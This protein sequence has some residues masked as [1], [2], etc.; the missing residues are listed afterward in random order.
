MAHA[1]RLPGFRPLRRRRPAAARSWQDR[2]QVHPARRNL[3]VGRVCRARFGQGRAAGSP[4]RRLLLP[5]AMSGSETVP[6]PRLCQ[7]GSREMSTSKISAALRSVMSRPTAVMPR[8]GVRTIS[9][10]AAGNSPLIR[11]LLGTD[12]EAAARAAACAGVPLPQCQLHRCGWRRR[13]GREIPHRPQRPAAGLSWLQSRGIWRQRRLRPGLRRPL[14][15]RGRSG[16]PAK[17]WA[18]RCR[19]R[20]RAGRC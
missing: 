10:M 17:R 8:P 20:G 13:A 5:P 18:R 19:R 2:Q 1:S 12:T 4:G 6:M 11:L 7:A 14:A 15:R 16:S 3:T 9:V